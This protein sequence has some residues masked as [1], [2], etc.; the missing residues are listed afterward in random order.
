[1]ANV[2]EISSEMWR[3]KSVWGRP[4]DQPAR[5][6]QFP[7]RE[8]EPRPSGTEQQSDGNPLAISES[9]DPKSSLSVD[10]IIALCLFGGVLL[11]RQLL[12]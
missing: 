1:M 5:V 2:V 12:P 11:V 6:I 10:W 7:G 4:F 3:P 8:S 9:T